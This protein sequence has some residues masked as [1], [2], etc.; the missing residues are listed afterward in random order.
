MSNRE[1][2]HVGVCVCLCVSECMCVC[3]CVCFCASCV[4]LYVS[5]SVCTYVCVCVCVCLCVCLFLC[6]LCECARA[7]ERGEQRNNKGSRMKVHAWR[8]HVNEPVAWCALSAVRQ[9]AVSSP[10]TCICCC[11]EKS[12][13]VCVH[14]GEERGSASVSIIRPLQRNDQST[15]PIDH[16]PRSPSPIHTPKMY[17]PLGCHTIWGRLYMSLQAP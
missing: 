4:C 13:L 2:A 1:C 9:C 16:P 12:T 14:R 11:S 5:V 7:C 10:S 3:V 6:I 8:N 17:F 15:A